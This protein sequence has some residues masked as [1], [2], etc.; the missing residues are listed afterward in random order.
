[1]VD[2]KQFKGSVRGRFTLT[3]TQELRVV[4]EGRPRP[5]ELVG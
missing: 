4:A 2:K 1:M 5:V 3:V